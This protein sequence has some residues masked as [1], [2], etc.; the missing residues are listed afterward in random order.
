LVCSVAAEVQE[1]VA[2]IA[3]IE[4]APIGAADVDVCAIVG[5]LDT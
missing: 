3:A 5:S 4:L 1:D 2:V